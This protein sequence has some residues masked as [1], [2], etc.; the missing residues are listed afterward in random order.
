MHACNWKHINHCVWI[1]FNFVLFFLFSAIRIGFT[2]PSY[3]ISR[4]QYYHTYDID[5]IASEDDRVSQQTFGMLLQSVAGSPRTDLG[6][7]SDRMVHSV[8][9]TGSRIVVH[10]F[11]SYKKSQK[12]EL[13]IIPFLLPKESSS[14]PVA[15][16]VVISGAEHEPYFLQAS[17]LYQSLTVVIT[18]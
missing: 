17:K 9:A 15:F 1:I 12:F 8:F 13:H 2:Q 14:Y 7:V 16:E 10:S 5:M 18:A 6:V 11:G 4:P 3:T